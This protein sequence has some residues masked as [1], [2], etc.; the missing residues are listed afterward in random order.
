MSPPLLRFPRQIGLKRTVCRDVS[1]WES[2]VSTIGGRASTYTSLYSFDRYNERGLPDYDFAVMDRAWWD[3]DS[4]EEYGIE[5]V[6]SDV[7][8]L[9]GRLDGDVRLVATGRGFH[10]YQFFNEPVIGRQWAHK[11][12]RYQK[13][14]AHGLVSLDGV[15]YPE[16]L[17]R[18]PETFNP[19][20]GKWAV[21]CDA[22][23]FAQNPRSYSIPKQP[24]PD[25]QRMNP[26]TGDK[27]Q[28]GELFSLTRWI[29]D[30]PEQE[31]VADPVE[32]Q[33]FSGTP[34][35]TSVPLP[36]CL[37][38]A[39]RVSNPPHHVRVAL[40]QI[41]ANNL[42]D[43]AHPQSLT[44]ERRV[45]IINEIC[46]FIEGLGWSDYNSGVTRKAVISLMGYSRIPSPAWFRRNNL[47]AEN[48]KCWYCNGS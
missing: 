46:S 27:P 35:S 25:Y 12:D 38:R 45:E 9:I 43:F 7:A 1:E 32:I 47:C 3:F 21:T 18:I 11:L 24:M 29:R 15:G 28:G 22:R 26:F 8:A 16:K 19:K 39:I 40:V 5:Q 48:H 30:N 33:D 34:L 17:T 36:N 20:R 6:K 4:T 37:D 31:T 13:T 14:M 44:A 42:R 41:M 2:Y 10:V 23:A